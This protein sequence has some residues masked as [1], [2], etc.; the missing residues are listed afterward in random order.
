MSI[1]TTPAASLKSFTWATRRVV[2][3]LKRPSTNSRGRWMAGSCGAVSLAKGGCT[4][5]ASTPGPTV[6]LPGSRTRVLEPPRSSWTTNV[7]PHEPVSQLFFGTLRGGLLRFHLKLLILVLCPPL[8]HCYT[9]CSTNNGPRY[10]F[11]KPVN[12]KRHRNANIKCIYNRD[13]FS[14]RSFPP[15]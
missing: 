10:E 8:P 15:K 2:N 4:A 14:S 9:N 3:A 11:R 12:T 13:P 6:P 1:G 7:D 5:M